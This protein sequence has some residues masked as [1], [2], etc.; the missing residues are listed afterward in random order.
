M[1]MYTVYNGPADLVKSL[2]II[3]ACSLCYQPLRGKMTKN[4]SA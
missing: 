2:E 3:L 4:V 1:K